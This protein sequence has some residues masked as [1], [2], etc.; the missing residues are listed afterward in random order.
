MLR[1]VCVSLFLLSAV[2]CGGSNSTTTSPSSGLNLSGTWK[3]TL[4]ETTGFAA[5]PSSW[6]GEFCGVGQSTWTLTQ[7]GSGVSGT[8]TLKMTCAVCAFEDSHGS[9]TGT[10][11][12]NSFSFTLNVG[13][14][15][16]MFTA[17]VNGTAQ[18]AA[19]NMDGTYTGTNSVGDRFVNG[20]MTLVKQ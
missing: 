19:T 11:S 8:F 9:V 12:G 10:L 5:C 6:V 14:T 13:F 15:P 20:Q 18:V 16:S 2:A 3:G 1:R 7:S 17:T 4:A